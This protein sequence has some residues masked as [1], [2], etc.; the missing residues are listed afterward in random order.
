MVR[1]HSTVRGKAGRG[2]ALQGERK[3][4]E[5]GDEVLAEELVRLE[6]I[7]CSLSNA[8]HSKAAAFGHVEM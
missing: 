5:R 2:G 4:P 7:G 6:Y 1:G 8:N 3:G